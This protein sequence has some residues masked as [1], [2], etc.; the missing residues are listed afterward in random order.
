MPAN[1]ERKSTP[2]PQAVEDSR[3][4]FANDQLEALESMRG[5]YKTTPLESKSQRS[6]AKERSKENAK[7]D[8]LW[9]KLAGGSGLQ[10]RMDQLH[11]VKM[12]DDSLQTWDGPF[13]GS[14][15]NLKRP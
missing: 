12:M 7:I 9:E 4:E 13:V 8:E 14:N 15:L 6:K 11:K 3:K 5:S 1:P 10:Q 2:Y